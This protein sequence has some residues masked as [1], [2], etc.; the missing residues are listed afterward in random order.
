[1]KTQVDILFICHFSH[2]N[3][4]ARRNNAHLIY[5]AT[6]LSIDF[7]SI[8]H[9]PYKMPIFFSFYSWF[10]YIYSLNHFLLMHNDDKINWKHFIDWCFLVFLSSKME[11]KN[12]TNTK[13]RRKKI[14]NN[15]FGLTTNVKWTSFHWLHSNTEAKKRQYLSAVMI[16][17]THCVASVLRRKVTAFNTVWIMLLM[18]MKVEFYR[19]RAS[20]YQQ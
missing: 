2:W 1:M 3:S 17:T 9:T 6:K 8:H 10:Y 7:F 19:V 4:I 18:L 14:S 16:K 13:L 11:K 12:K 5:K 15:L 20:K